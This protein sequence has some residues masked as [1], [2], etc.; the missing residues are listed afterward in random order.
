MIEF[1]TNADLSL[2]PLYHLYS[3]F[4]SLQVLFGFCNGGITC[5]PNTV[6]AQSTP[7]SHELSDALLDALND[8]K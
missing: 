6:F 3:R 1:L 2:A 7:L 5:V 4:N 8:E